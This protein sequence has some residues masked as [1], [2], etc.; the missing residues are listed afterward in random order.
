[1]ADVVKTDLVQALR[2]RVQREGSE[3]GGKKMTMTILAGAVVYKASKD[4]ENKELG[5]I[6]F[7]MGLLVTLLWAAGKVVEIG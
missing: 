7:A 4:G 5:R 3:T 1:M 2:M 6:A